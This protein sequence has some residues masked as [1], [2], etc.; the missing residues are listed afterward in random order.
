MSSRYLFTL[1]NPP[2]WEI[3][4][5]RHHTN[6]DYP[7]TQQRTDC[8][9]PK[10]M[11]ISP[12][13]HRISAHTDS[14]GEAET[15]AKNWCREHDPAI[16]SRVA[17]PITPKPII[18]AFKD[19][20]TDKKASG[21][22]RG[23]ISK[24]QTI[25][26]QMEAWL[27]KW[28]A[29]HKEDEQL[30]YIHQLEL[31]PLK[32]FF[33]T[34]TDGLSGKTKSKRRGYLRK[35]FDHALQHGWK[36]NTGETVPDGKHSIPK[37]NPAN[38]LKASGKSSKA[39]LKG[40]LTDELYAAVLAACDVYQANITAF[41]ND[42]VAHVGTRAKTLWKLMY[43]T[44]FAITDAVT[45]KRSR[46]K[47]QRDGSWA[48]NVARKKT[49]KE[50]FVPI[51]RQFAME[52]KNVPPGPF[53]HPEYFFWSGRGEYDNAADTS[54]K[55]WPELLKLV[56]PAIIERS[57]GFDD[58]G[59]VIKP[60]PHCLRYNFAENWFLAGATIAEVARM[61]GDTQKVVEEHYWKMSKKVQDRINELA[62][63]VNAVQL[64]PPSL[65][66][67]EVHPVLLQ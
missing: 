17:E 54:W 66:I 43:I 6:C 36:A 32:D 12:G 11:Y 60:T 27:A 16:K 58:E 14:W 5:P 1:E 49:Q 35:M 45:A 67:E 48:F 24:V 31:E 44:G 30:V 41:R 47:Q 56:E 39:Q 53:P 62:A 42:H 33:Q 10:Y 46:L 28:N 3:V 63:K 57:M 52:L 13:R 20:I 7:T 55:L 59:Q 8:R 2:T 18:E 34:S 15:R 22:K 51:T 9:C 38:F 50:V 64:P 65:T 19:F 29:E 21:L 23:T 4:I 61:L 37:S 40:P 26:D 25:C